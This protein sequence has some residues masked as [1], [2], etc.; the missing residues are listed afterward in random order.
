[1]AGTPD[2]EPQFAISSGSGEGKVFSRAADFFL[3]TD[4]TEVYATYSLDGGHTWFAIPNNQSVHADGAVHFK[5]NIPPGVQ[6]QLMIASV[7]DDDAG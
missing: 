3:L 5:W 6:V 2:F 7:A 1:M 4:G